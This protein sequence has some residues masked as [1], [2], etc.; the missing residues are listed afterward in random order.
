MSALPYQSYTIA[1][2]LTPDVAISVYIYTV[3]AKYISVSVMTLVVSSESNI[4][5]Y[6]W[7]N[8]VFLSLDQ[9]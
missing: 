9:I 7:R 6:M 4:C 3:H 8:N 1:H 2:L 5:E